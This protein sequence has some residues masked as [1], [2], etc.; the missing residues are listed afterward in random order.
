MEPVY[1]SELVFIFCEQHVDSNIITA[2]KKVHVFPLE[3]IVL[4]FHAL[5]KRKMGMSLC[6]VTGTLKQ[7]EKN[8]KHLFS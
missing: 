8:R 6:D 1:N 5:N 3:F 4:H 2:N 7:Q